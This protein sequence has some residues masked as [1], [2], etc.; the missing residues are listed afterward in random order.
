MVTE[1]SSSLVKDTRG[2]APKP[3][4]NMRV[5]VVDDDEDA[6]ELIAL[7]LEG[8]GATVKQAESVA[9]AMLA[10]ASDDFRVLVSDIGMP[11]EDGYDLIRRLR[12][13][14]GSPQSRG[15]PAIAVTAFSAP[16]DRR[17]ALAA[18]FQEHLTKPVDFAALIAA[19]VLLATATV[20]PLS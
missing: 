12:S 13:G 6:R 20:S 8:A 14:A 3:L 1:R 10:V 9:N 2:E 17:K 5:L 18:G 19:V 4:S 15:V 7:V 11:A 16:E